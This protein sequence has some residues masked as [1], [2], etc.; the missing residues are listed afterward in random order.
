[1]FDNEDFVRTR[2]KGTIVVR[3]GTPVLIEDVYGGRIFYKSLRVGKR[4][5]CQMKEGSVDLTPVSLGYLSYKHGGA[6]SAVYLV[7]I[8]NR[9]WKQGLDF[10]NLAYVQYGM[11][12]TGISIS[13]HLRRLAD[14]IQNRYQSREEAYMEAKDSG[15][16]R[17]FC[18]NF[19][20][21][22]IDPEMDT[23]ELH[24]KGYVIG[25]YSLETDVVQL[26]E[27]FKYLR[28]RVSEEFDNV[29]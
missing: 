15:R 25:K 12:R 5:D 17:A 14:T 10:K 21:M 18:R 29:D 22:G 6:G 27:S 2:L 3:R 24:Y 9:R 20:F 16:V 26:K 13:R 11:L 19:A 7:R 23:V 4:G 28:E 8:P 1:M